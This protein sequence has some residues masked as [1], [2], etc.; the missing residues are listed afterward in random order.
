[1]ATETA[2]AQAEA[3]LGALCDEATST[4]EPIIIHRQGAEDVA[5]IA[6]DELRGLMET[7]YLLRSPE[8]ARRLL[9][10]LARA[11]EERLPTEPIE[12]LRREMGL[13]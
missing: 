6:A 3:D 7:A 13:G 12:A 5:R 10:A 1:M 9:T 8:N 2:Y 11:G 4:R